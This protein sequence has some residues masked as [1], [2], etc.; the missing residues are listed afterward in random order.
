MTL[1]SWEYG[2]P[3]RVA[4]QRES[5]SCKGC[6]HIKVAFDR[7]Y[8]GKGKKFGARCRLYLELKTIQGK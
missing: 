2:N 4:I 6:S 5:Q 8:C 7:Q 3:E 1:E